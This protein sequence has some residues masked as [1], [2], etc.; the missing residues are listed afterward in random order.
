MFTYA[1]SHDVAPFT[2]AWIEIRRGDNYLW[3]SLVAPFTGA[4]IEILR[5]SAVSS[6]KYRVAPF[7]GAWIEMV[8]ELLM[9]AT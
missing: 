2:G 3:L 9:P 4:W 5:F 8:F 7:T 1:T 6:L